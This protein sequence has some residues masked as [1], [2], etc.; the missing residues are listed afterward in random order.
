M[1]QRNI[2]IASESP[3]RKELFKKTGLKFRVIPPRVAEDIS[4]GLKPAS[5]AKRLALKKAEAVAAKHRDSVVIGADTIVVSGKRIMG[6]PS[7]KKEAAEMLKNLSGRAHRVITGIAVVDGKT[8]RKK[9]KAV[10][11]KVF[12]RRLSKKEIKKYVDSGETLDKA[13]SYGIQGGAA[14]FVKKIEG[15]YY[16]VMGLPLCELSLMLR[17]FGIAGS[18]GDRK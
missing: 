6:R 15:D 11:T 1:K 9:T 3:R 10:E 5:F 8:G 17:H 4:A 2:I 7:G 13:G 18:G 14:F 16:N 12:F